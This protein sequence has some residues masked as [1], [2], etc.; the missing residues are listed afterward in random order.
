MGADRAWF[1]THRSMASLVVGVI[2][3]ASVIQSGKEKGVWLLLDNIPNM[4]G[5]R[6]WNTKSTLAT[7]NP[8]YW[9]HTEEFENIIDIVDN[10]EVWRSYAIASQ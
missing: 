2:L 6:R 7:P 1:G 10:R 4:P 9:F 3:L 8:L 5:R